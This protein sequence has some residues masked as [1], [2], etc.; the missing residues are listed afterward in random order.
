MINSISNPL[1]SFKSLNFTLF[2]FGSMLT[3][4]AD[5][6]MATALPLLV[7]ELTNDIELVGIV[8]AVYFLPSLI[9]ALFSGVII[10]ALGREKIVLYFAQIGAF[11][12]LSIISLC[13]FYGYMTFGLLLF[14]CVIQGVF[15]SIDYPARH[16]FVRILIKD[17]AHLSNAVSL[18]SVIS[19]LSR[20]MGPSMAA[21]IIAN[22]GLYYCF[23]F[24]ALFYLPALLSF[25]FIKITFYTEQKHLTKNFFKSISTAFS[26]A[27]RHDILLTSFLIFFIVTIFVPNYAVSISALVKMSF[28][29]SDEDFAYVMSFLGVG[30]LIGASLNT[31]GKH[32]TSM[33]LIFLTAIGSIICIGASAFTNSIFMLGLCLAGTGFFFVIFTNLVIT[34]I[35]THGSMK[36]R[37]RMMSIYTLVYFSTAPVGMYLSGELADKLGARTAL[38]VSSGLCFAITISLLMY[39]IFARNFIKNARN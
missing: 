14:F 37:G 11:L 31:L 26:Y 17:K 15:D 8:C 24:A 16:S 2:F 27:K 18:M 38:L 20:I 33:C 36:L 34:C 7:L 9:F 13:L 12:V 21:L 25:V 30:L 22:L 3:A 23:V 6:M 35:Q 5:C 39:K 4:S 32:R 19:G 1:V 29:A 10:D 28:K